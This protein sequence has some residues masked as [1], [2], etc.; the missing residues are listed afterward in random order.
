MINLNSIII[1]DRWSPNTWLSSVWVA[2]AMGK[3][4]ARGTSSYIRERKTVSLLASHWFA[5]ESIVSV[6]SSTDDNVA[7]ESLWCRRVRVRRSEYLDTRRRTLPIQML[8]G[9]FRCSFHNRCMRWTSR[10]VTANKF[11]ARHKALVLV[12][13]FCD[14]PVRA[15]VSN[16]KNNKFQVHRKDN[17]RN[18][19]KWSWL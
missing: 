11:I 1:T 16:G 18:A 2:S 9:C 8:T 14:Y 4:C 13:I 10:W 6:C 19:M 12:N 7:I 15:G 17:L 3:K 5:A